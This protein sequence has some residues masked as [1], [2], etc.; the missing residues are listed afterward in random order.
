[1]KKRSLRS[2]RSRSCSTP[3]DPEFDTNPYPVLDH[4]RDH[5]P[6]Y[7]WPTRNAW[8]VTR[9]EDV[10]HVLSDGRFSANFLQLEY[11]RE[12]LVGGDREPVL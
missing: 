9:F 2:A 4:L 10:T 7:W 1:M 11:V 6:L 5:A 12:R 3:F 8:M